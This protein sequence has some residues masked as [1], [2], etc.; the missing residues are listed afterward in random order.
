MDKDA[1]KYVE[2]RRRGG[3]RGQRS[4]R[5]RL[6]CTPFLSFCARLLPFGAIL[7]GGV[8]LYGFLAISP[9]Y[10]VKEVSIDGNQ[11]MTRAEAIRWANLE[12]S[13]N[14]FRADIRGAVARLRRHPWVKGVTIERVVPDRLAITVRERAPYARL[15][16]R[17]SAYLLDE[18]GV[19]LQEIRGGKGLSETLP[20]IVEA[21]A[22]HYL[23]GQKP[24]HA[25]VLRGLAVLKL[26]KW[27][28][29]ALQRGILRVQL[30]EKQ[31]PVVSLKGGRTRI[32]FG[33]T[34]P[35]AAWRRLQTVSSR[36]EDDIERIEQ[37][38]LSFDS[39][40]VV[41]YFQPRR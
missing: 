21:G 35:E 17:S 23:P 19:I 39:Q 33:D 36:L 16:G 26:A 6:I 12:T 20:E 7:V 10:R 15:V 3:S 31:G 37:I 30:I 4:K 32:S 13:G 14:I 27:C 5:A 2:K 29:W 1:G 40:V 18:E 28:P 25:G 22:D 38:S 24:T 34:D 11:R 9:L 41:R 8:G